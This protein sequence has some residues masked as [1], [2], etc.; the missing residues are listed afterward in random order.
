MDPSYP[1][2]SRV[3]L[4]VVLHGIYDF[5]LV[6]PTSPSLV[7]FFMSV[8]VPIVIRQFRVLRQLTPAPAP[9]A[10]TPPT[11]TTD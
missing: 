2:V 5:I 4:A 10:P 6:Y 7:V 1:V 3:L 11:P 8:M 9:A